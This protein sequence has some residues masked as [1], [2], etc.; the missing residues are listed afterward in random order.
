MHDAEVSHDGDDRQ[1]AEESGD[2]NSGRDQD[3]SDNEEDQ[4]NT[5]YLY[6]EYG[7]G[8]DRENKRDEKVCGDKEEEN[9]DA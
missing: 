4:Y 1:E 9:R 5:N 3:R 2:E 7:R 8:E 6:N